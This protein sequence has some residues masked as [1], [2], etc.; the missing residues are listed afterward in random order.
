MRRSPQQ[1]ANDSETAILERR[2]LERLPATGR[3]TF[4]LIGT[5]DSITGQLV[6]R[7]EHGFRAIHTGLTL[8]SGDDVTF[9]MAAFQGTARVVWTRAKAS[10]RESGFR[11]VDAVGLWES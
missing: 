5:R 8:R 3:I 11:I 9:R 4:C 6:D 2:E 7:S 1:F 10:E